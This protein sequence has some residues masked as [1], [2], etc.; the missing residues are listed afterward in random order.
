MKSF[1][2]R[3][4]I[5]KPRELQINSI[6][7][8]LRN[9]IWNLL[10]QAF[11][12]KTSGS[13]LEKRE[14]ALWVSIWDGFL[15]QKLSVFVSNLNYVNHTTVIPP[16]Y[17]HY[18]KLEWSEVYDFLEYVV[19]KFAWGSTSELDRF[20]RKLNEVL[21]EELAGFRLSNGLI[22]QITSS[23]ELKEIESAISSPNDLV[24]TQIQSALQKLTDRQSPDFRNAIKDSIGAVETA[25]KNAA[26]IAKGTLS[27][28]LKIIRKSWNVHPA[29]IEGYD[30]LYGY[31]CDAD[32][33]RHG[34]MDDPNLDFASAKYM[35][36]SCSAFA[37]YL[38]AESIQRVKKSS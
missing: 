32:G 14:A 33:I 36:V 10:D 37:N 17:G 20:V 23:L 29:L 31:T 7:L 16:L 38:V 8:E 13:W 3:V 28:A 35:V 9:R 30:K 4:G 27:D 19:N 6:D 12:S 34:L 21:A 5:K 18:A 11:W 22:V 25:A 15:K 2:E 1:S 24:A 26:G